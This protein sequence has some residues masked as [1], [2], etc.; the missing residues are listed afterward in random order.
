MLHP[1]TGVAPSPPPRGPTADYGKY[2]THIGLCIDCHT[3]RSGLKSQLDRDML[4]AGQAHPPKDF[5][6]NPSNLT[7]DSTTGIGKWT[8]EDFLR[9]LRTGENPQ[10]RTLNDF[11]PWREL[12]RMSDDDLRAVYRYLRSVRPIRNQVPVRRG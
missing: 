10:G 5:T 12:R 7:P 6:A 1:I 9:T 2:L 8:E 4:F 11:M 3:S